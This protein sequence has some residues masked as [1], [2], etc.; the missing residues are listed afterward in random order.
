MANLDDRE[1]VRLPAR[2][3]EAREIELP[4]PSVR[5][6]GANVV[7]G[8]MTHDHQIARLQRLGIVGEHVGKVRKD[9]L[10]E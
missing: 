10:D 1:Q 9:L 4:H 7:R 8:P 2:G 5:P 6:L 3:H